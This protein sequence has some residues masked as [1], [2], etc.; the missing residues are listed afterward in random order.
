MSQFQRVE[1]HT[2]SSGNPD[3]SLTTGT[4]H[5]SHSIS[6]RPIDGP[7]GAPLDVGEV[8]PMVVGTRTRPQTR[9]GNR[10]HMRLPE[11]TQ[12]GPREATRWGARAMNSPDGESRSSTLLRGPPKRRQN[13]GR[14]VPVHPNRHARRRVRQDVGLASG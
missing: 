3:L 4:Q 8:Q 6:S 9:H 1:R 10:W 12:L 2:I 7:C 5:A 11:K 14:R 13:S